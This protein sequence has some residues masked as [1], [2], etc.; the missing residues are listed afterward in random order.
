MKERQR[1][2]V[3]SFLFAALLGPGLSFTFPRS[4]LSVIW[5]GQCPEAKV[6]VTEEGKSGCVCGWGGGW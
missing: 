2:A 1:G 4:S 6:R 5:Q 3:C